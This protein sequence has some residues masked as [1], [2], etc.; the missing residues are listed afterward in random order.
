MSLTAL[1]PVAIDLFNLNLF[2]YFTFISSLNAVC[3]VLGAE[4]TP[5]VSTPHSDSFGQSGES[6]SSAAAAAAASEAEGPRAAAAPP[7]SASPHTLPEGV[8]AR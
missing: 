8:A 7:A 5:M 1:R 4:S 2:G 3:I 6:T